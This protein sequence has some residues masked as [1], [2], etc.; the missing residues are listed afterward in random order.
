VIVLGTPS[1]F[2]ADQRLVA[3]VVVAR[4]RCS[5]VGVTAVLV[6]GADRSAM[7]SSPGPPSRAAARGGM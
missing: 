5:S 2:E 6:A 4:P 1:S 3:A 7:R